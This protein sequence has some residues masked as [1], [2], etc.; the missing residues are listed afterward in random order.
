[1]PSVGSRTESLI[2]IPKLSVTV[3]KWWLKISAISE[4]LLIILPFSMRLKDEF[5]W[6]LSE[7]VC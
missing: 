7:N 1:M 4:S 2:K 5:T 3:V 6:T